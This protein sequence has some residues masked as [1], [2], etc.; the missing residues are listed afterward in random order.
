MK[1]LIPTLVVAAAFFASCQNNNSKTSTSSDSSA[2]GDVVTDSSSTACFLFNKNRDTANLNLN[3]IDS[4]VSGTLNY[5]LY[6]K[7]KNSG[8][9]AGIVKGDTIIADYTF[10]SEG[11]SSVRQVV[12]LKKG[13]QLIEG[14]GDVEDA[15]GKTKFKNIS[16][17]IFGDAIVFNKT[18]CK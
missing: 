8:V 17:L 12:W 1:K 9:I 14:F 16:K 10:Q 2:L 15:D 11:T 3:T 7:D 13:D 5:K 6:E 18:T 4:K